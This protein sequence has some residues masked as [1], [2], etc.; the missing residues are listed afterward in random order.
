M[1]YP[2]HRPA[3]RPQPPPPG[4]P[5]FVDTSNYVITRYGAYPIMVE[6]APGMRVAL[7]SKQRHQF[8]L[9]PGVYDTRF[10][11]FY[12]GIKVG[13]AETVV[14][15]RSGWP[16]YVGYAAPYT[17]WSR[18]RAGYPPQQRGGLGVLVG[19]I[20]GAFAVPLLGVLV[21]YLAS[22]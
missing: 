9:P 10:Y 1:T 4:V 20:V 17:I 6:F 3:Q 16:V 2:Q 13:R 18:G 7:R 5:V 11:T 14:D 12:F 19:I 15:T 8:F 21:A 22:G